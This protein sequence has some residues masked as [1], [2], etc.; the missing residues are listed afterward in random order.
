MEKAQQLKSSR[1]VLLRLHKSL[2]DFER[3]G[4]ERFNGPMTSGQFLNVLLND[5]GFEWLRKFSTLIVEIDEMFDLD[6]GYSE[7]MVDANLKKIADLVDM[8]VADEYFVAKYQFALQNVPEITILH[9][10][11]KQSLA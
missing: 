4:F 9:T 6:D 5:S 2:V 7:E 11:L 1:D 10:E 3:E 8:T